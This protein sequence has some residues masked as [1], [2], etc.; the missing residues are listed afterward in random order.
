MAKSK[1]RF[2][3]RCIRIK[4]FIAILGFES[5]INNADPDVGNVRMDFGY[6]N[7]NI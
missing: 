6:P 5:I 3:Y 2:K 4:N 1:S 7:L